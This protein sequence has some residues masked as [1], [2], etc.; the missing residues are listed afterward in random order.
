M[1]LPSRITQ[2]VNPLALFLAIQI[3]K[4]NDGWIGFIQLLPAIKTEH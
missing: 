2:K 3:R 1:T 4:G